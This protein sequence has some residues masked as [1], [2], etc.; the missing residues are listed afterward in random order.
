[1]RVNFFGALR[2]GRGFNAGWIDHVS[3]LFRRF[4]V[5]NSFGRNIDLFAGLGVT[6]GSRV[7]LPCSKAAKSANFNFVTGLK[8]A[9]DRFK[10]RIDDHFAI[11]PGEVAEGCYLVDEISF[12]HYRVL[13]NREGRAAASNAGFVTGLIINGMHLLAERKPGGW[14]E[15]KNLFSKQI[16][17]LRMARF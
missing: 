9:D 7:P 11:A 3:Q 15:V 2:A 8:S 14:L 4:E 17:P 12:G 5:R 1:M 6:A 13:S 16:P 10:E